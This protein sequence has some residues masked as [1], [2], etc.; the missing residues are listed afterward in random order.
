[1]RVLSPS[2][3]SSAFK[4]TSRLPRPRES[5]SLASSPSA[6]PEPRIVRAT[7]AYAARASAAGRGALPRLGPDL[8]ARAR[9]A[10]PS[11]S[12]DSS[13]AS[14]R[15]RWIAARSAPAPTC[16]NGRYSCIG[17]APG[18]GTKRRATLGARCATD[19]PA[20]LALHLRRGH[21]V[22]VDAEAEPLG[23]GDDVR[24][25]EERPPGD[26]EVERVGDVGAAEA[27]HRAQVLDFHVVARLEA[28]ER[29]RALRGARAL[30]LD[31]AAVGLHGAKQRARPRR[32]GP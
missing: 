22:R 10:P 20:G 23:R 5:T 8:R 4:T 18:S 19:L 24:G 15:P 32:A 31:R 12:S 3:E 2:S 14:P 16:T 29:H 17:T 21:A 1:M 9:A 26:L 11:A 25:S 28:G 27:A 7:R 30:R 13:A 6:L